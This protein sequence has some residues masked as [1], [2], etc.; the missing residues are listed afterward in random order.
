MLRST[1]TLASLIHHLMLGTVTVVATGILATTQVGCKDEGK[2]DYWVDKLEE[3]SWQPRAVK[4]LEQFYEDA[5]TKANKDTSAPEVK[6]LLDKITV[7]LT[8]TYVSGYDNFD[9]KTRTSLIKLLSAFRDPRTEPALKKAFDEFVKRPSTNKDDSDVKWAVRGAGA[10]KLA[11]LGDSMIQ[12]FTKLRASTMLGGITYKDF[13]DALQDM[14]QP[15]WAGPL[16]QMLEA[17]IIIPKGAGDKDKLDPYKDQLFWQTTSALLLGVLKDNAAVEPLMKIMLDPSK[18]DVQATALLALVK[19]GR[20]AVT[21][22]VKLL[23]GQHD[24]F[25][26][27]HYSR[28][29][30]SSPKPE[31]WK[32]PEDQPE[33]RTA[34]LILGTI[35]RTEAL[36]PMLEVLKSVKGD[37][38][39]AVIAREVAKIPAT[40]ESK[41]AFKSAF[42]SISLDTNIP[43]GANA[44]Q[45]LVE[46]AGQF[47][48]PTL[49]PW[50]LVRAEK[51]AGSG[52]DKT[53]LQSAILVTVLKLA[54]ADQLDS[55]RPAVA[56]YG[57]KMEKDF[58]VLAEKQ[59]RGCGDRVQCYL[60]EVEKSENQDQANQFAGFKA[61]YMSAIHGSPQTA[62]DLIDRLGSVDNAAVRYSVSQAIDFLSPKGSKPA[63]KKLLAIIEANEKTADRNKIANDAPLKQ[64]MYRIE[65][66]AD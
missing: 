41:E 8:N 44:L 2:P 52:D 32:P 22:A 56:K 17:P 5:V 29:K 18:A 14:P 35:G 38:N 59:L 34:A 30:D 33:V 63:A 53:A 45:V 49:I 24:K 31:E 58:L 11:S 16:R 6:A 66:R 26:Q 64:V 3:K 57:T 36:A 9:V 28:L 7:P 65:S 43:P 46:S 37:V 19:I 15:S 39:K 20:P 23:R 55:L 10:L 62:M 4:R 60:G 61:C 48:D 12:A 25:K 1:R 50:L 13:N 42:E 54:K 27:Y 21:E 40:A 47:Y 51:T